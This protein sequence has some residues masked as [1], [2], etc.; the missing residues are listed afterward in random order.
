MNDE[1]LVDSAILLMA[2]GENAAAEV[3]R[4]LAPK[5]VHRLGETMARLHTTSRDKVDT[6]L[7]RFHSAS[8]GLSTL[9]GNTDEYLRSVLRRALG[10]E[11]A[12]LLIGRILQGDGVSG[13]ESLKWMDP[14]SIAELIRNEHPQIVASILVHL[15]RDQAAA[16]LL[17]FDETLRNDVVMRIATLDG[18]QPAALRE[19]DEVLTRVLAGGDALSRTRL[20]GSKTAAEIIAG[21][22]GAAEAGALEALREQDPDL[23]QKIADLMFT[24]EDI[25]RLDDRAIQLLLREVQS[26]SLIVALKG[27]DA[28]L[29]ER[30][31]RNMSQRAAETLREDLESKGPV[32]ISEVE[33]QQKEIVKTLRRLADEGQIAIGGG[34]DDALV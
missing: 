8:A 34:G 21:F 12:G 26:E 27:T 10:E 6:V 24:F 28:A 7:S 14:R 33:S 25:D 4:H 19:L 29:R 13:I 30:I 31:F 9:V 22:G 5:E 3:F 32:R 23:A 18:I 15:E 11:R 2:L 1:G 17:Q 16:T 20:D